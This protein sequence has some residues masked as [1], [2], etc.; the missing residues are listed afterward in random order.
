MMAPLGNMTRDKSDCL[1]YIEI[2]CLWQ[3]VLFQLTLSPGMFEFIKLSH[4]GL[5]GMY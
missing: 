5:M 3:P 1:C 4:Y 2:Q